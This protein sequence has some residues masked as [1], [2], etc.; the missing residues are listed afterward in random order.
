MDYNTAPRSGEQG[1]RMLGLLW[2]RW[3]ANRSPMRHG[4]AHLFPLHCI[5][6]RLHAV[7]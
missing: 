4:L 2:R 3:F 1:V 5:D 7:K 6:F